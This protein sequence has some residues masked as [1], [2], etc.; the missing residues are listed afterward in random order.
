MRIE[1][2]LPPSLRP[3]QFQRKVMRQFCSLHS[4]GRNDTP[5]QEGEEEDLFRHLLYD[6]SKEIIF[7]YVPKGNLSV[8]M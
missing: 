1:S 4:T 7:C 6:D 8:P 5:T 3:S 2:N